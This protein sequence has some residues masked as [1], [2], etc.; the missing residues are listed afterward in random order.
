MNLPQAKA[1]AIDDDALSPPPSASKTRGKGGRPVRAPAAVATPPHSNSDPEEAH[2]EREER[3]ERKERKEQELQAHLGSGIHPHKQG[4]Q[5]ERQEEV[6]DEDHIGAPKHPLSSSAQKLVRIVTLYESHGSI[7]PQD[8]VFALSPADFEAAQHALRKNQSVW[9]FF[10]DQLRYDWD[11]PA[12]TLTIRIPSTFHD[13]MISCV[14]AGIDAAINQWKEHEQ[15]AVR[16]LADGIDASGSGDIRAPLSPD[17]A[18]SYDSARIRRDPSR[19]PDASWSFAGLPIFI[20]EVAVSETQEQSEEKVAFYFEEAGGASI[21]TVV[22]VYGKDKDSTGVPHSA[23]LS[24]W[25]MLPDGKHEV[26]PHNA[27]IC[28]PDGALG[29]RNLRLYLS[30][31]VPY[32]ELKKHGVNNHDI[33]YDIPLR[34][35]NRA[36]TATKKV[37]NVP[38]EKY[39]QR[40]GRGSV[41]GKRARANPEAEYVDEEKEEPRKRAAPTATPTA[42]AADAATSSAPGI[43][44]RRPSS[45]LSSGIDLT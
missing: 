30:E 37:K 19:S 1:A 36:F 31:F 10:C 21:N 35:F 41:L 39:R 17:A 34:N 3:K 43:L 7:S 24:R 12:S 2:Q 27:L 45:R 8:A 14:R 26:E 20:V 22:Y 28:S 29:T 9:S 15:L 44:E 23:T 33:F 5:A 16:E 13:C 11:P 4:I 40:R 38:D 6:H 18:A 25:R 32:D 42:S